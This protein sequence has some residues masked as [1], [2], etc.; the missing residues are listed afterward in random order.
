VMAYVGQTCA[1]KLIRKLQL[2][3]IGEV[4]C[5]GEMPP[6]R[7]P[8]VYDNGAFR[9]HKA[10]SPFDAQAFERDMEYIAAL[11]AG[12]RPAW[13]VLPDV[14]AGGLASLRESEN[15]IPT[16]APLAPLAL[17]VQDGM[18]VKDVEHLAGKV[19]VLFVG[20]SPEWKWRTARYWTREAHRLGLQCHIG[21]VGSEKWV[22]LARNCGADSI[23]SCQPL[24][25]GPYIDRWI[26]AVKDD[27]EQLDFGGNREGEDCEAIHLP[28]RTLSA[29][30]RRRAQVQAAARA[31]LRLGDHL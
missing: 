8:W 21:K 9:D 16:C 24:W 5:R 26:G 31:Q 12:V 18:R 29:P 14:V 30:R 1:S 25:A 4:T 28:G 15:W 3:G 7:H 11:P 23:D 10:K 17:A 6:R 2:A 20:G 19:A 13:L 27:R 22:R